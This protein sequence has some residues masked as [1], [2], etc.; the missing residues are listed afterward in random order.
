LNDI[1]GE[2][3]HRPD[4]SDYLAHFTTGRPPV[5]A[6]DASNPAN[7]F[8]GSTAF[9][10]LI[11]ILQN[12]RIV[13]SN[14]PWVGRRAVCFTE[15]PWSSLIDHAQRYSPYGVGFN[16]PLVFAA[17]G[18]PVYY[19]RADHWEKQDWDGDLKTFVTP[20]WPAYRPHTLRGTEHLGGKTIDY[21]HERE[22]RIPHDFTFRLDQVE[23]VIVNTYE[24]VA[25]FPKE[26]KDSIGRDKFLIM[27]IY[28]TIERIWPVHNVET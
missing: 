3:T 2:M 1:E 5:G 20:F 17:G 8:A 18:G 12:G 11:S 15:C 10:K 24:D 13:A 22:W 4:F 14:M 16:K 28:R 21:S 19:V 26:L 27:D 9:D 25:K 7:Q 6:N 23:F